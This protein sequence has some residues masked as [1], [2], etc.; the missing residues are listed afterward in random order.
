MFAYGIRIV[1]FHE[2]LLNPR[3]SRGLLIRQDTKSAKL[4]AV[5]I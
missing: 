3:Q 2:L 1:W 5:C 4:E